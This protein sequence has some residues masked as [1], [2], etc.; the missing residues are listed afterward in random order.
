MGVVS[1]RS[2]ITVAFR[3]HGEPPICI[4]DQSSV[5]NSREHEGLLHDAGARQSVQPFSLI[6]KL[7]T[8]NLNLSL[9]VSASNLLTV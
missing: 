6:P 1:G 5:F 4:S 8:F 9:S 7:A 3:L 2:C